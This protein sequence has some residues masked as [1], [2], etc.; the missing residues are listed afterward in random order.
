MKHSLEDVERAL[1]DGRLFVNTG[2]GY[3]AAR[4]SGETKHFD[5]GRWMIIVTCRVNTRRVIGTVEKCDHF[6][7]SDEPEVIDTSEIPEANERW[8][9]NAKL[10]KL[11]PKP[12]Q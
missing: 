6:T 9:K 4:R 3:W 11:T 10:K 12:E 1:D 5:G 8:F 2:N 7:I